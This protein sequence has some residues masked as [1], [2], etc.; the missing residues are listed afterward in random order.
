MFILV[1][2]AIERCWDG[3][4]CHNGMWLGYVAI[5]YP[6][7]F[8]DERHL[9]SNNEGKRI[10]Q[11]SMPGSSAVHVYRTKL[12]VSIVIAVK[13]R[14]SFLNVILELY[15][16]AHPTRERMSFTS[17]FSLGYFRLISIFFTFTTEDLSD[18]I[19][20]LCLP[21]SRCAVCLKDWV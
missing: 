8:W 20:K 3:L 18:R 11:F 15:Q 7:Y 10:M 13:K 4:V 9:S 17:S 14:G 12:S 5:F 16:L 6:S 19:R 21:T 1:E 2:Y